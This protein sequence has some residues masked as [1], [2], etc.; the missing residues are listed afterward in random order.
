M[1]Y[2]TMTRLFLA[3]IEGELRSVVK[4][5]LQPGLEELHQMLAYHMGW[6]GQG[7]GPEACGKRIRP[8]L[9]LMVA[10]AAGGEWERALPAAAAVELLH[11][12]SLVHDDIQ[13]QSLM[14]RARPTLW[15]MWGIAQAIN[16]GDTLFTLASLELN[17]LGETLNQQIAQEAGKIFQEACLALTQ[18]QYLDMSYERR[19]D[20]TLEEYFPMV[21]GKTAALLQACTHLGAISAHAEKKVS[22]AYNRFGHY[23]GMAFQMQDDLLG[24]WGDE[25]LTGK[26]AEGDLLTGKKTLPVL[27]GLSR[28]G[29]FAEQWNI[30]KLSSEQI[31]SLTAQLEVEGGRIY[32]IKMVAS[33]TEQALQAL[34]DA[35][36][37]EMEGKLIRELVHQL[38]NRQD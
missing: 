15:N 29:P 5:T 14:R 22:D 31:P 13:D 17:R 7:A 12:F 25:A 36:P 27:Y 20:V 26:S 30:G 16:A 11:N 19:S 37:Q 18:G 10:S 38:L 4:R 9:V 21:A 8:L 24:I 3:H 23:F 6:A 33:F 34:D 35:N 1:S 2:E 32:T 28:K